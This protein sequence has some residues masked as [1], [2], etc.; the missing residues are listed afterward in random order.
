[1]EW[2]EDNFNIEKLKYTKEAYAE[3]KYAFVSD[4]DKN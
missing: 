2:N 4:V 3:G 1:M